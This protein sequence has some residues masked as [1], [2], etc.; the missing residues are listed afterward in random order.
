MPEH[1]EFLNPAA[2]IEKFK[3]FTSLQLISVDGAKHLWVGEPFVHR[4]LSEIV[5][6]VNP[7]KLPLPTA[8]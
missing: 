7:I 3:D 2:A 6:V 1:D 4:V 8:L 5:A